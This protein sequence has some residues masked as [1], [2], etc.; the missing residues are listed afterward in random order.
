MN[1][2]VVLIPDS[3]RNRHDLAISVGTCSFLCRAT[4]VE[5]YNTGIVGRNVPKRC[6]PGPHPDRGG[7]RPS[8]VNGERV[9]INSLWSARKGVSRCSRTRPMLVVL[10]ES[11][12]QRIHNLVE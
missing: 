8:P 4:R 1:K 6:A 10:L 12:R 3:E 2:E 7:D 5:N 9:A 11:I